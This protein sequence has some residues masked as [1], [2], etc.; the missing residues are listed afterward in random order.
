MD[1]TAILEA[2]PDDPWP[3]GSLAPPLMSAKFQRKLPL[4]NGVLDVIAVEY[5]ASASHL[6]RWQ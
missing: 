3:R 1:S 6:P 5:G 4:G 2:W